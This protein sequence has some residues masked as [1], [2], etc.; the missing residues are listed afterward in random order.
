MDL[1]SF[2]GTVEDF[3]SK[4]YSIDYIRSY[5]AVLQQS[6]RF[7]VFPKQARSS[8]FHRNFYREVAEKNRVQPKDVQELLGHSDVSTT[9]N[10]YAHAAREAKRDSAK[11]LDKVVGMNYAIKTE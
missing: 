3:I 4:R 2:G 7:A 6:F 11:L 10:V 8:L 1:L 5:S 9:M